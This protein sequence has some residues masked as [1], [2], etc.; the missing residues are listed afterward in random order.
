MTFSGCDMAHLQRGLAD[1]AAVPLQSRRETGEF[2]DRRAWHIAC[3]TTRVGQRRTLAFLRNARAPLADL[4]FPRWNCSNTILTC[5]AAAARAAVA[6]PSTCR[7]G[8][9]RARAAR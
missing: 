7:F 1:A 8:R 4:R 9:A 3:R 5:L 2:T 6:A